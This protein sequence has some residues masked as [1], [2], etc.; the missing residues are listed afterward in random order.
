[1]TDALVHMR[2]SLR[3]EGVDP[4]RVESLLHW[5]RAFL[6]HC[7]HRDPEDLGRGDVKSFLT[8]V[9]REQHIGQPARLRAL[10]AIEQVFRHS[11]TGVPGWLRVLIEE[12]SR[13]QDQPN[14]LTH[15]QVARLLSRLMGADWLAAALIYG[16][17]LRL[18]ECVRL[19][20]RDVD[21]QAGTLSVRNGQDLVTRVLSIPD[22]TQ[23]PLSDHLETLRSQHI[24]DIVEGHGCATLPPAI[25]QEH[26]EFARKW[27]WQYLFVKRL[28]RPTRRDESSP[29]IVLHHADPNTLHEHFE[30]AAV[31]AGI[32]R[33]VTGHVLRNTFAAHMLKR[34]VS[35]KRLERLLGSLNS[36]EVEDNREQPSSLAI[37]PD[38]VPAQDLL[39]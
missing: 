10:E 6:V 23:Q 36:E 35:I 21:L 9:S 3:E 1:M 34:G 19:R 29:R 13:D 12:E 38:A 39:Q 8:H 20:V 2:V 32:Y 18:A 17:G 27:H 15:E 31:S 30:H 33:R 16:T 37:P 4:R 14:V 24:R 5:G 25:G 28:E 22:N 7:N 26:P 11:R